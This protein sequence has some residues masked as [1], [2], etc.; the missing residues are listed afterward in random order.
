[1]AGPVVQTRSAGPPVRPGGARHQG[2]RRHHS[3]GHCRCPAGPRSPHTSRPWRME[4]R[5]HSPVLVLR[6]LSAS[7]AQVAR[8]CDTE[9]RF[10]YDARPG[11]A[12]TP[13]VSDKL[14]GLV[15][16]ALLGIVLNGLGRSIG[17]PPGA[18]CSGYAR[19]PLGGP[20]AGRQA[21]MQRAAPGAAHGLNRGRRAVHSVAHPSDVPAVAQHRRQDAEAAPKVRPADMFRHRN[22]PYYSS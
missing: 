12:L 10:N 5:P 14:S 1:M 17:C 8:A 9:R 13:C 15:G 20:W 18:S 3:Q 2:E 7:N 11:P 21:T 22:T 6:P 16:R 4:A 19:L